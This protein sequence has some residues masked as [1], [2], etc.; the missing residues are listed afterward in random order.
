MSI[1][2]SRSTRSPSYLVTGGCGFLGRYIVERLAN[3]G[4]R[5]RVLDIAQTF[6]LENV[7]FIN[8]D[9]RELKVLL[10]ACAGVHTVFHL[11]SVTDPGGEYKTYF[12]VNVIGTQN[13]IDAC[14]ACG[15]K[16]LIYTSSQHVVYDG[17]DIV[18]GEETLPYPKKHLDHYSYTKAEGERLVL[19]A[20]GKR[21]LFTCC[22]RPVSLF[23]P[24]DTHFISQLVGKARDGQL[25]H[26][27]G[28]GKNIVDYT[29]VENAAHAHLL[30]ADKLFEGSVVCGQ[31]Y[32]ITNGEPVPF[33]DF[34]KEI[35]AG[36][37]CPFPSKCISFRTAYIFAFL[38]EWLHWL[39]S[40]FV[41]FK[42]KL[43][44]QMVVTMAK[45]HYFCASKA[46]RDFGYTP[47]VSLQEGILRT[48]EYCQVESCQHINNT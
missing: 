23:G 13:V 20:N 29:Y 25:N 10:K 27:I 39:L 9:V 11:A 7:E 45:N 28:D 31:C 5:V 8:G 26:I 14:I 38:L 21:S 3:R 16:K 18:N 47:I 43:T 22:I 6:E 2:D 32:F 19:D 1:E 4:D 34:I 12:H 42:P 37:G 48:I 36:V 17:S 30:A 46:A 35:L 15:V 41:H 33:W 44:R 24:R 40:W